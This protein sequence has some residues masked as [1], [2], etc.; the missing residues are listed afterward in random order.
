MVAPAVQRVQHVIAET[1]PVGF[2]LPS[3][4][5]RVQRAGGAGRE[6]VDGVAAAFRLE[7]LPYRAN[8]HESRGP[9]LHFLHAVEQG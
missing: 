7:E 3:E 1:K 8:L 9:L 2:R 6:Q 5:E 4:L